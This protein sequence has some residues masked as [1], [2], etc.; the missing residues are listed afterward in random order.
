MAAAPTRSVRLAPALKDDE[1]TKTERRKRYFGKRILDG[2]ENSPQHH[3]Q[4]RR[5]R[6]APAC[7]IR[8][9]GKALATNDFALGKGAGERPLSLATKE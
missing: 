8:Q 4:K 7:G 3:G 5:A 2:E 1:G 6:K 9:S